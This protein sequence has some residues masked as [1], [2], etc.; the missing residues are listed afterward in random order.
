MH[1]VQYVPH[2]LPAES[3]PLLTPG[4]PGAFF[5]FS[6]DASVRPVHRQLKAASSQRPIPEQEASRT[7]SIPDFRIYLGT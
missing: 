3:Q 4:A 7:N 6:A 5:A 2:P 1:R